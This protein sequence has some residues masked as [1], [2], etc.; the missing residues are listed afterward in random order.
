MAAAQPTRLWT[1]TMRM[2]TAA[3]P[4]P[5]WTGS[6]R[7]LVSTG[8]T[9]SPGLSSGRANLDLTLACP[10]PLPPSTPWGHHRGLKA[11]VLSDPGVQWEDCW[12]ELGAP[13][14][15]LALILGDWPYASD[16][17]SLSLQIPLYQ[18]GTCW[19]PWKWPE[20]TD[21]KMMDKDNSWCLLS[22]QW[23]PNTQLNVLHLLLL[24]IA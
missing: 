11:L 18:T 13:D 1:A 16:L 15:A 17:L 24:K 2:Q 9:F 4:P 7:I 20:T 8:W 19:G 10:Y 22:P 12:V 3:T 21:A 14:E 23:V 6:W 5:G